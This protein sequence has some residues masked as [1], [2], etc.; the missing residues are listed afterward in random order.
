[1][2]LEWSDTPFETYE[3][4]NEIMG[5]R[6]D[7][8]A[9]EGLIEHVAC[10]D[11]NGMVIADVWESEEALG[12]FV[13]ERLAPALEEAGVPESQP[14]ILQTH[15]RLE[16]TSDDANVLVLIDIEDFGTDTYDQMT[17]QMDAHV[18]GEH[19]SVAHTAAIREDGGI[20]VADVW[21]SPEAFGAFAQ[22]QI[23]PAG[24]A[25]GLG[26]FEPRMVE[27]KNRIRGKVPESAGS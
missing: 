17:G 13:D 25:A 15:N 16:G 4:V 14:R 3:R 5:I 6:G 20:F 12:K 9:P 7:A 27:V 22:E 26:E 11:G 21:E 1:M 19:P 23:A 18:R 24:Q 8:D 2:L 10:T